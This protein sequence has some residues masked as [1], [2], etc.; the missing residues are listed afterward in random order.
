[1]QVFETFREKKFF[2]K[3][4]IKKIKDNNINAKT[5]K[6]VKITS[7]PNLIS[8][9]DEMF[10]TKYIIETLISKLSTMFTTPEEYVIK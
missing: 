7:V 2:S 3:N 10:E 8:K 5:R 9:N 1:M 6:S 4:T